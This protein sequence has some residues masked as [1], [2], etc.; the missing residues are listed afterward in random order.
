MC[1]V[2]QHNQRLDVFW[3]SISQLRTKADTVIVQRCGLVEATA[4]DKY[5]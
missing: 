3:D 2:Y 1:L 5:L 4:K